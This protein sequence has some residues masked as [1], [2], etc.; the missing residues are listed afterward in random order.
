MALSSKNL[1]II[2]AAVAFVA[3][4]ALLVYSRQNGSP[5]DVTVNDP[6][7]TITKSEVENFVRH[8][9]PKLIVYNNQTPPE[10]QLANFLPYATERGMKE[11]SAALIRLQWFQT[12]ERI[13]MHFTTPPE[14]TKL[15]ANG[16]PVWQVA[17]RIDVDF[18]GGGAKK[19]AP[20][21]VVMS[22]TTKNLNGEQALGIDQ[23]SLLPAQ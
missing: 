13:D 15:P 19:T 5:G 9:F 7:M 10:E 16:Q 1:L 18:I 17:T 6:Q 4:G 11:I 2:L 3:I 22:V 20:Y 8:D 12:A 21:D 23:M 14:A